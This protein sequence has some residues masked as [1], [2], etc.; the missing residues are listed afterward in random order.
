MAGVDEKSRRWVASVLALVGIGLILA[1]IALLVQHERQLEGPLNPPPTV[2]IEHRTAAQAI[3]R[4]LVLV[5]VLFGI[6]SV[7]SYAFLR[8]SRRFRQWLLYKPR[9]ATPDSDVWAMHRLPAED[10][11]LDPTE[12][13]PGDES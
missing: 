12:D 8:W 11:G 4:V 10:E 3:Q 2:S 13:R 1:G 7:V 9:P 6:F 5:L